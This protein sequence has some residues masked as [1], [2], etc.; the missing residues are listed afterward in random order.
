MLHTHTH[1]IY[2]HTQTNKDDG[3]GKLIV[4]AGRQS[5][6]IFHKLRIRH[7]KRRTHAPRAL[8]KLTHTHMHMEQAQSHT[9]L[10]SSQVGEERII[11]P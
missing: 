8:S 3:K 10:Q 7:V 5:E 4:H 1:T 2:T 9:L 6:R 11:R